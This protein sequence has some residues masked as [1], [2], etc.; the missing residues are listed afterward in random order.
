M[1]VYISGIVCM[2]HMM[3][4]EY[5]PEQGCISNVHFGQFR[6]SIWAIKS[7]HFKINPMIN[8]GWIIVW[9]YFYSQFYGGNQWSRVKMFDHVSGPLEGDI[10]SYERLYHWRINDDFTT[11]IIKSIG[12][13]YQLLCLISLELI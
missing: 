6:N 9:L 12:V 1:R 8:S 13:N 2:Y 10:N 3:R 7:F 5:D 11:I 4:D